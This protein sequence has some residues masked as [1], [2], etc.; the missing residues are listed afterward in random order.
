MISR[1]FSMDDVSALPTTLKNF[2]TYKA[3][4]FHQEKID[5]TLF[6]KEKKIIRRFCLLN[7]IDC[8]EPLTLFYRQGHIKSIHLRQGLIY[9]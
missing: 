1:N 3:P 8:Q 5:Y 9:L 2:Q 4:L 7:V 6:R